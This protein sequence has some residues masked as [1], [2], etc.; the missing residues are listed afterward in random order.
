MSR[1]FLTVQEVVEIHDDLLEQFGGRPGIQKPNELASAVM[2][3]QIGYYGGLI[4]EAAA[5]MESLANNHPFVDGN[6][7]V[8]FFATDAFLRVNGYFIDCDSIEAHSHFM[9]L[10]DTNSFRFAEL[11][12]WLTDKVKPLPSA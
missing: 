6:K 8:T 1:I 11:V 12:E 9:N 7:R 2:R 4:D 3:P 5:F 10:F